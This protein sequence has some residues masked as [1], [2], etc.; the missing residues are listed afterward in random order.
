M[1]T[2]LRSIGIYLLALYFIPQIVPG[3]T[4]DGGFITILIGAVILALMFMILKPI[5]NIIS[6]PVNMLTLGLFS[7]ITNAFILYLLTILVPNITVQ[8]FTYPHSH[9]Y[10]FIT[11]RIPFDTFFAY[12]YSAFILSCINSG[13]RWLIK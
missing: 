12:V 2:V 11:P 13:I 4:I 5:L 3:F 9:F 6:F 10:G 7:I 1:K 8:P